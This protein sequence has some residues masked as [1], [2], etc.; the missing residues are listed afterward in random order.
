[1]RKRPV[2]FA[3]LAVLVAGAAGATAVFSVGSKQRRDDR[4][5]YL[6]YEQAVLVPLGEMRAVAEDMRSLITQRRGGNVAAGPDEAGRWHARLLQ[7][8]SG[9]L[10]LDPPS[11]LGDIE[12]RLTATADAYDRIPGFLTRSRANDE[13]DAAL[14]RA[15]AVFNRAAEL[16]QLHRRRLGLGPTTELPDPASERSPQ[17]G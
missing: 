14:S 10:A 3:T 12:R 8:R 17:P 16:M 2:L 13:A 6:V 9:L 15:D 7:A 11:F 5:A 4:K 1:M